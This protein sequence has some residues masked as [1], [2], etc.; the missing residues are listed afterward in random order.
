M[1]RVAADVFSKKRGWA[2]FDP[3][4]CWLNAAQ[5]SCLRAIGMVLLNQVEVQRITEVLYQLIRG[6]VVFSCVYDFVLVAGC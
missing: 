2:P 5:K 1:C 6:Y 3:A 4:D